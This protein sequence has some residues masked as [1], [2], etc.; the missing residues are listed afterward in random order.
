MIMLAARFLVNFRSRIAEPDEGPIDFRE[1]RK[2]DV[3][4]LEQ[5][6]HCGLERTEGVFLV[7]TRSD[8]AAMRLQGGCALSDEAA[9][10]LVRHLKQ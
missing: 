7:V 3:S 1:L 8:V 4:D 5:Q 6:R 10:F 2:I 9:A